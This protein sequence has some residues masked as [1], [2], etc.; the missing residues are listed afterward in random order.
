MIDVID[1][2]LDERPVY[3][4][5]LEGDLPDFRERFVLERVPGI[6]NGTI[7]RVTGRQPDPGG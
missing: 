7:W 5:R 4:I 3:L 1:G 6:P 2:Y